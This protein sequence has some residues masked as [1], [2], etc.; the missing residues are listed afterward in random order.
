MKYILSILVLAL[1]CAAAPVFAALT[2]TVEREPF[3]N[4]SLDNNNQHYYKIVITGGSGDL[5]L[6]DWIDTIY[7]S[8]QEDSFTIKGITQ[9]GY[10]L[11]S[12]SATSGK[13]IGETGFWDVGDN[14]PNI[15]PAQTE[16]LN[17]YGGYEYTVTR[18]KYYLG[19]FTEDDVIEIYM[20]DRN[21]KE[22]WSWSP[23]TIYHGMY[24][25][26]SIDQL[27]AYNIQGFPYSGF[28]EATLAAAK[29][30][31]PV[32]ELDVGDGATFF[33][34]YPS[35]VNDEPFGSPLP[36]GLPT[37]LTCG[38]FALGFWYVRRKKAVA[39]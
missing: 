28:S 25:S 7:N 1:V 2:Y 35:S 13:T 31:M 38:I 30:A 32:A 24:D 37:A 34:I 16:K 26:P 4:Q 18:Y 39:A 6:C 20:K 33:G 23:E 22:A 11:L 15:T 27:E 9:Y 29:K 8:H 36:G 14:A 21:G 12:T 3:P 10:R 5:Y 17:P 19:N